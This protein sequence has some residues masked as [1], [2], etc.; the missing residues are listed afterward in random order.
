M[1][2]WS[3]KE[4]DNCSCS[5]EIFR[6]EYS[7]LKYE[8]SLACPRQKATL[9]M[10]TDLSESAF[11]L[12]DILA[13]WPW[14]RNI[15]PYYLEAKAESSAWIGKFTTSTPQ[16]QRMFDAGN[17]DLLAALA[18]PFESKDVL[19]AGCDLMKLFFLFDECTDVATPQEAQEQANMVMD[20]IRNPDKARPVGEC[21][22]GEVARQFWLLSSK[23][24]C[25]GARRRFIKTFDEYTTSVVH[26]AEDRAQNHIRN[27]GDYLRVRR[28]TVG[29]TSSL[30]LLEFSLDLPDDVFDYPVIQNLT[31]ACVDLL[32]I[33]NDLKSY[34][35][36]QARGDEGHNIVTIVMHN[37]NLCLKEAMDWIGNY[38]AK[39]VDNF[40]NGLRDVPSFGDKFQ[41]G[42]ERYLD[43]LGNWVTAS[44]CWHFESQ[45]Y[46]SGN[47]T[48]IQQSREVV[49]LP[50]LVSD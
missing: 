4:E 17:F 21:I 5:S 32:L 49:L 45:R 25:E 48:E 19:R 18:Y 47:G 11:I 38:H 9:K 14:K 2:K 40:L 28:D 37:E 31:N 50:R 23:S 22:L 1:K 27:V 6:Q 24:A 7:S 20:A 35:V 3:S 44:D 30:N 12:P 43:G 33:D 8:A 42:V 10:T 36:E 16:L 34:N 46:F 26:Q 39:V 41:G 13:N 15:N 29:A